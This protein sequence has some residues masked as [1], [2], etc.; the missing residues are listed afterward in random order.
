MFIQKVKKISLVIFSFIIT[1]RKKIGKPSLFFRLH[2]LYHRI[3]LK[4]C[5]NHLFVLSVVYLATGHEIWEE[6]IILCTHF[7]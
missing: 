4:F 2:L 1:H 5:I 7:D 3:A 6:G